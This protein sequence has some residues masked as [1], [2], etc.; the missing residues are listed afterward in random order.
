KFN[1]IVRPKYKSTSIDENIKTLLDDDKY[2][3]TW[4]PYEFEDVRVI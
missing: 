2:Q 3:L 4:I 1:E